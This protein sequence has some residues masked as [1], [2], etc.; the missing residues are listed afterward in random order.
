MLGKALP[1]LRQ[2]FGGGGRQRRKE[3]SLGRGSRQQFPGTLALQRALRQPLLACSAKQA[4]T[5]IAE[6]AFEFVVGPRQSRHLIAVEQ[7]RPIA[8]TDRVKVC[9]KRR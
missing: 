2:L 8:P 7:A 5:R 3:G 6:V 4:V 9:A 1:F